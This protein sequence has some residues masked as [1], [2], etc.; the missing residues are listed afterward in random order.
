MTKRK[1]NQRGLSAKKLEFLKI[2]DMYLIFPSN[3]QPC[4]YSSGIARTQ[5]KC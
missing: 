3:T 4:V 2:V 5:V 1:R